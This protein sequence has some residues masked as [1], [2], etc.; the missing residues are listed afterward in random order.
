MTTAIRQLAAEVAA[1][2]TNPPAGDATPSG[3]GRSAAL[4]AG[5]RLLRCRMVQPHWWRQDHGPLLARD[6]ARGD[7]VALLPRPAG[8]LQTLVGGRRARR[9]DAVAAA[10]L[11]D[12]FFIPY[13]RWPRGRATVQQ[14]L[15]PTRSRRRTLA[16]ALMVVA[17]ALPPVIPA[18][19]V[20]LL[21]AAE[22]RGWSVR[23]AILACL[24]LG[25]TFG[26]FA[27]ALGRLRHGR[28]A[29]LRLHGL[30]WD[31][32]LDTNPAALRRFAPA[33]LATRLRDAL[34]AAQREAEAPDRLRDAGVALAVAMAVLAAASPPLAVS[35]GAELLVG[36]AVSHCLWRSVGTATL[37]VGEQT[38]ALEQALTSIAD[39]APVF[40]PLQ[41]AGWLLGR[42]GG[43]LAGAFGR[44]ALLNRALIDARSGGRL[45]LMLQPLTVGLAAAIGLGPSAPVSLAAAILAACAA[46]GAILRISAATGTRLARQARMAAAMPVLAVTPS[47]ARDKPAARPIG[48]FEVLVVEKMWFGYDAAPSLLRGIDLTIR[49]G[50]IVAVTGPSGSGRATL[51]QIMLGLLD[52]SAGHVRVNG[53]LLTA[54]TATDFHRRVGTVFPDQHFA[55]MTIR[56]AILG[57]DEL[58][59]QAA[60][61]AARLVG[62][63]GAIAR[64]PMGMQTLIVPGIF[65]TG[66]IQRLM[67]ARALVTNPELLFLDDVLS[68]VG[69]DGCEPLFCDLRRRGTTIV[70]SAH[71]PAVLAAADRVV[72]LRC[73]RL[74]APAAAGKAT[75]RAAPQPPAAA[76]RQA[77]PNA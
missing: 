63:E 7:W 14:W 43:A 71:D 54:Q 25:G 11:G 2:A 64:L 3:D 38:P 9:L 66:L 26:G 17:A 31:R 50:E 45:L 61:D 6:A 32:L 70:L 12:A 4:A 41:A 77:S 24:T 27:V 59:L 30:L 72:R 35:C 21:G 40:R 73:G 36:F 42:I 69:P 39:L 76:S 75:E 74:T 57:G 18:I 51:L 44:S 34:S 28:D 67:L 53:N 22:A 19:T 47:D 10:Q 16:D 52:P 62:L 1:P 68:A 58:P 48:R 29:N 8:G 5:L 33:V 37:A 60:E 13:P 46:A 55:A 65:P 15:A 20:L 49:R 23:L 56:A